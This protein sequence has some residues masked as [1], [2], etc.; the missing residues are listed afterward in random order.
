LGYTNRVIVPTT[1]VSG[2]LLSRS[3]RD[4]SDG[5]LFELW[6][7]TADGP[8][9]VLLS[10]QDAVMFV[11]RG[12]PASADRRAQVEL[13]ALDGGEVDALYFRSQRALIDERER[14]REEGVRVF[15]GDVRPA[16][17]FLMERFI[18][19]GLA[20]TGSHSVERGVRVFR[21]PWITAAESSPDLRVVSLDIET[22]G[23]D[24]P[25]LS[26]A[27]VSGEVRRVFLIRS[28]SQAVAA[29]PEYVEVFTD[30]A[31][32]LRAFV[33]WISEFDPDVLI[34]WNVVDFDLRRLSEFSKRAK[35]PF[36]IGRGARAAEVFL[37]RGS[38]S[39]W[40]AR[41]PG[42]V[43]LDGIS[44][45]RSATIFF[46]SYSLEDVAQEILGRGKKIEKEGDAAVEIERMWRE[47]PSALVEYNLEDCL[48]VQQIFERA[49][50]TGFAVERQRLTG[51]ALD[52]MGGS[53]AAFDQLY[54]PRLHRAGF[55]APSVEQRL[56][57]A[58]SPGGYVMDSTP[59][60]YEN[61]IV[62]DFKSLY[63]SIIRTF[64]VDPLGLWRA[65]PDAVEGYDEA[66]FSRTDS[67]LPELVETLWRARDAAK[68]DENPALSQAIK[69]MMNSFYG[70][71]G[72]PG[73]RFFDSR[74]VSSI[75][76]RGHQILSHS[77]SIIEE[78][79]FQVIYGDTDSLF[80]LLG[81]GKS[82]KECSL[83]G[84][85]LARDLTA[86]FRRTLDEEV[87][88]TSHLELEYETHY[89]RFL[90][91][92]IRG[93]EVGTKKRYAGLV[94]DGDEMNVVFKGLE[95]VRTDWTPLARRF[96]RELFRRVFLGEEYEN[97]VRS[98]VSQLLAGEVDSELAYRKRL[99]KPVEEYTKN[100]PPHVRAARQLESP[101]RAIF[102]VITESGPE[103]VQ[104]LRSRI[105]YQHYVD[106][107]LAPAADSLLSHL[108]TSFERIV[109]RQTELWD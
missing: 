75:T 50:L 33:S 109:S 86:E 42:R 98:L 43:V 12:E 102:Y 101:G 18:T 45:L 27:V 17:R 53:V 40:V 3:H 81:E 87:S 77:R 80:V 95:A 44:T 26:I 39:G 49:R 96:Q 46:E 21:N 22:V 8:V 25:L 31:A 71:L 4:T 57:G 106:R 14:L 84:S 99:K 61:V 88:L 93:S 32:C 76:K 64:L 89:E 69:I 97:Y 107:Q 47:E 65:G 59:G 15:E 104:K 23:F 79:G 66:R 100:V 11:S 58:G 103:P 35:V 108:G 51:L 78:K 91:P 74:L 30:E 62:L 5:L 16:E 36:A 13:R 56:T 34:G 52:R 63:P 94:R 68:K 38:T 73:C 7:A 85:E 92:T 70:V 28:A 6:L 19:S 105:D 20:V 24:G 48:L 72:S 29:L 60:L 90:M 37:P 10:G 67:I 41:V 83:L 2:F 9:L 54:L 82:S 1:T 55:V